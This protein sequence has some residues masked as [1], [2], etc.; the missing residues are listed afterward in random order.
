MDLMMIHGYNEQDKRDSGFIG[1]LY[2]GRDMIVPR[3]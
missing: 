3:N 1:A 2:G